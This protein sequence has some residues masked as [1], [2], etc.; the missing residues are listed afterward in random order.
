MV[1]D[2]QV[3]DFA[4]VDGFFE[5]QLACRIEADNRLTLSGAKR[6]IQAWVRHRI[7]GGPAR[8]AVP[9]SEARTEESMPTFILTDVSSDVWVESL[10]IDAKALGLGEIQPFSVKK[11]TLKG[12][13]REGVDLIVVDNGSLRFSVV[14][15]RGM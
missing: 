10:E 2:L 12:G 13:R 11:Q 8:G 4:R 7:E 3:V 1:S 6:W 9:P 5:T 14:P 15:T